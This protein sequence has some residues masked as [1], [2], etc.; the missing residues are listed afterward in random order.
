MEGAIDRNIQT[1]IKLIR[2]KYLSTESEHKP[3]D[4]GRKVQYFTMDIISDL[5]YREPFGYSK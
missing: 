2:R 5:A 1:L 4:F 3:M